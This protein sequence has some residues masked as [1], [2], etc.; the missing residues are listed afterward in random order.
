MMYELRDV[1]DKFIKEI[2]YKEQKV[3]KNLI[4]I[5]NFL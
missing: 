2:T 3:I 5:H 4:K 1:N